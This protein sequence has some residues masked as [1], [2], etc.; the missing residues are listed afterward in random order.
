MRKMTLKISSAFLL[1]LLNLFSLQASNHIDAQETEMERL[2]SKIVAYEND[3][4]DKAAHENRLAIFAYALDCDSPLMDS[5]SHGGLNTTPTMDE[6]HLFL[7]HVKNTKSFQIHP[8]L[9]ADQNHALKLL[10]KAASDSQGNFKNEIMI[11][12]KELKVLPRIIGCLTNLEILYLTH[13]QIR[14]LSPLSSLSNLTGLS[15]DR[16]QIAD[17]SPLSSLSNLTGLKL[18]QNQI[19]DLSPLSSLSNL[20]EIFIDCNPAVHNREQWG[21][22]LAHF[23]STTKIYSDYLNPQPTPGTKPN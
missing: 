12:G 17:L 3:T 21:A 15:L 2:V 5:L 22:A 13:N 8:S 4:I 20:T 19:A 14:D 6:V 11:T 23:P 18:D 1:G 10:A 16:N 7:N 9:S